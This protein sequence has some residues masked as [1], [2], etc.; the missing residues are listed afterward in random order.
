M[1][2]GRRVRLGD[3]IDD[4]CPRCKLLLNHNIASFRD[5]RVAKVICRTCFTEHPYLKGKAAA[6]KPPKARASSFDQVLAKVS[7]SAPD[8]PTPKK[9][10]LAPARYITRHSQRPP[11]GKG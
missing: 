9:R 11:R 8:R 7:T 3:L 1:R 5:N 2:K 6:K 10:A 4:Y